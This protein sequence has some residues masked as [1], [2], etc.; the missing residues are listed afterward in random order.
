MENLK[1]GLTRHAGIMMKNGLPSEGGRI[2]DIPD[3]NDLWRKLKTEC[4]KEP[5]RK[6]GN[7]G[8]GVRGARHY[9]SERHNQLGVCN[10]S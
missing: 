7:R 5:L 3:T 10:L 8:G 9:F 6:I 2:S 4:T 1:G